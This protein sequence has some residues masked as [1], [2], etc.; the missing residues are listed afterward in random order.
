MEGVGKVF[1]VVVDDHYNENLG[2][3]VFVKEDDIVDAERLVDNAV[4]D[5]HT[6][7]PDEGWVRDCTV[8]NPS[9]AEMLEDM[10]SEDFIGLRDGEELINSMKDK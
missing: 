2:V 10:H 6:H 7:E 4:W 3:A 8:C 9:I 1:A 5:G